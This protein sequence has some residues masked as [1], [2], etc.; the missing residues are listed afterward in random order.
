MCIRQRVLILATSQQ[1]LSPQQAHSVQGPW[2]A[3]PARAVLPVYFTLLA[4]YR[5]SHTMQCDRQALACLLSLLGVLKVLEGPRDIAA[6]CCSCAE[7]SVSM[8]LQYTMHD[9]R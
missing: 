1:P 7:L 3:H 9:V 6:A 4:F 2:M 8:P 5:M